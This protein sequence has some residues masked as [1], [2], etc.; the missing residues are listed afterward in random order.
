MKYTHR[1]QPW[2]RCE[3]E[4]RCG[5]Q[6]TGAHQR[7]DTEGTANRQS[8]WLSLQKERVSSSQAHSSL[9]SVTGGEKGGALGTSR[10]V[11]RLQRPK[12]G[13]FVR[14]HTLK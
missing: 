4:E 10:P 1:S 12:R 5:G 9:S 11:T 3:E 2:K 13:F 6:E 14:P 7:P 8:Y